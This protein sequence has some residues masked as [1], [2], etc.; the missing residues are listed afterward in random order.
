MLGAV[1]FSFRKNLQI[2]QFCI[3]E[4]AVVGLKVRICFDFVPKGPEEVTVVSY[5]ICEEIQVYF[6]LF[7]LQVSLCV[8]TRS[9]GYLANCSARTC[10]RR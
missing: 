10:E 4:L 3:R 9:Y 7:L 2:F 8:S 5:V 6:I 1:C